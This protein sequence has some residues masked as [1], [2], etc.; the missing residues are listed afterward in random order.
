MIAAINK[1]GAGSVRGDS[2]I[3]TPSNVINNSA[4]TTFDGG[5]ST[6]FIS[7]SKSDPNVVKNG[8]PV[9]VTINTVSDSS[10]DANNGGPKYMI[11]FSDPRTPDGQPG[12]D[13]S[14]QPGQNGNGQGGQDG[15]GQNAD[16]GTGDGQGDNSELPQTANGGIYQASAG[17]FGLIGAALAGLGLKKNKK[18]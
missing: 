5:S 16:Q 9:E 12:G 7:T 13:S 10:K 15:Q 6:H 8:K 11:G 1:N 14:Q 18:N 3:V 4:G 17:I 2:V